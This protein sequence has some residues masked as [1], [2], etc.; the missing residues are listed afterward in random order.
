MNEITT[1]LQEGIE[2]ADMHYTVEVR[3]YICDTPARSF[4][5]AT[6]G[7][8]GYFVVSAAPPNAKL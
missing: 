8:T 4:A 5:K 3:C 6:V 2:I 1:I 7:H